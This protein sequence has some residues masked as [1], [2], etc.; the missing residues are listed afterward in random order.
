MRDRGESGGSIFPGRENGRYKDSEEGLNMVGSR[1]G[2]AARVAGV[3]GTRQSGQCERA[4]EIS[5]A[6]SFIALS[7]TKRS[8][9]G[10][11]AIGGFE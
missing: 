6:R 11:G 5:G 8:L 4:R 10:Q 1:N 9:D 7:V 3:E 2:T